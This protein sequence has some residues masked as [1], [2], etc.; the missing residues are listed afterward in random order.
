LSSRFAVLS[1]VFSGEPHSS[2][3]PYPVV[4]GSA[5]YADGLIALDQPARVKQQMLANAV[6]CLF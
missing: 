2:G 5:S 6:L 3:H 1:S 4:N